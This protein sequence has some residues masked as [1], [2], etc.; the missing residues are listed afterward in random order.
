M[1]YTRV[2]EK[3]K[4]KRTRE[5]Q[6][7]KVSLGTPPSAV[8]MEDFPEFLAEIKISTDDVK[9]CEKDLIIEQPEDYCEKEK[10][11]D[12]NQ[13]GPNDIIS[14][15]V[16]EILE[17]AG[18]ERKPRTKHLI[19][20]VQEKNKN[21]ESNHPY[22]N[23]S[24]TVKEEISKVERVAANSEHKDLK[25]HHPYSDLT[26]SVTEEISKLE[27]LSEEKPKN[28]KKETHFMENLSRLEPKIEKKSL[29]EKIGLKLQ[30][31][32]VFQS[33]GVYRERVEKEDYDILA[34]IC[35]NKR[36]D[37]EDSIEEDTVEPEPYKPDSTFNDHFDQLTEAFN[38]WI[39]DK[40]GE[41]KESSVSLDEIEDEELTEFLERWDSENEK[42]ADTTKRKGLLD[43]LKNFAMSVAQKSKVSEEAVDME[44]S[45][46]GAIPKC[47]RS[48]DGMT[49]QEQRGEKRKHQQQAQEEEEEEEEDEDDEERETRTQGSQPWSIIIHDL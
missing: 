44:S 5:H 36:E 8:K 29:L 41:R 18:S 19:S 31:G 12:I 22:R 11:V 15:P 4:K 21:S 43:R 14:E 25:F 40:T 24:K 27:I 37:D 30:T 23:L 38:C 47:T 2:K 10:V 16:R 32:G 39:D 6:E 33:M 46:T 28:Q 49:G 9:S 1:E 3:K 42:Q 45:N 26:E 35:T 17:A 13:E 20:E 7:D 48:G 34:D